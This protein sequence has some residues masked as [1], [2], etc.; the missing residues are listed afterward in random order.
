M[1]PRS[2]RIKQL[3]KCRPSI[4]VEM[5]EDVVPD[6]PLLFL[7]VNQLQET[8]HVM[9]VTFYYD[10]ESFCSLFDFPKTSKGQTCF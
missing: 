1:L 5:T 4:G 8:Q 9:C 6:P 3:L 7:H 2:S 10:K